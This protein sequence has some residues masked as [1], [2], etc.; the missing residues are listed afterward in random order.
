MNSL[1]EQLLFSKV[2][3]DVE[4][5]YRQY[6]SAFGMITSPFGSDG[7]LVSD[8]LSIL[9]E[10]KYK[11]NS[12]NSVSKAIS[13]SVYYL[14]KIHDNG[15]R[16]PSIV[17]VADKEKSYLIPTER[18]IQL[19]YSNDIDWTKKPS[20]PSITLVA[21]VSELA[22]VETCNDSL[23]SEIIRLN[24]ISPYT[25][26]YDSSSECD[27]DYD[28]VLSII[29]IGKTGKHI[30]EI[31]EDVNDGH[32]IDAIEH[33]NDTIIV[34]RYNKHCEM[35]FKELIKDYYI[36]TNC[37]VIVIDEQPMSILNAGTLMYGVLTDKSYCHASVSFC[38]QPEVY[39]TS[40]PILYY[41]KDS[42]V[43]KRLHT[44]S[45]VKGNTIAFMTRP[46]TDL[47]V[48]TDDNIYYE[49][50]NVS[51]GHIGYCLLPNGSSYRKIKIRSI[52][53][54]NKAGFSF[55]EFDFKTVC[56][57]FACM[58]APIRDVFSTVNHISIEN[59]KR[60]IVF[61]KLSPSFIDECI[62]YTAF[63]P[64]NECV[65]TYATIDEKTVYVNN[66]FFWMT[67]DNVKTL[68]YK[69]HG[70]KSRIYI[71]ARDAIRDMFFSKLKLNVSQCAVDCINCANA[72][73][74]THLKNMSPDSKLCDIWNPGLIQLGCSIKLELFELNDMMR[75]NVLSGMFES[76]LFT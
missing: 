48:C 18:L 37:I 39:N 55:N 5:T 35:A 9:M 14:K 56:V 16:I 30:I 73:F 36:G 69:Y 33:N 64:G 46:M 8:T 22:F 51:K 67:A 20:G 24:S 15:Y 65:S 4:N 62:V 11:F 13:Q 60:A 41:T 42:L 3:K 2:E 25:R 72:I 21:M 12:A 6:L 10:F 26:L 31:I 34:W 47:F 7:Y 50:C 76:K 43:L 27:I 49:A 53:D 45:S 61:G 1:H 63:H 74:E 28:E 29:R 44:L 19:I 52:P 70:D 38:D 54:M 57:F 59:I 75:Y 58:N 40:F 68:A 66:E 71:N 17:L 32:R 23:I